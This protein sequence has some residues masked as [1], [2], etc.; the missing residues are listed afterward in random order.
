PHVAVWSL[1]SPFCL[2]LE[3][4]VRAGES[5]AVAASLRSLAPEP[6]PR[7]GGGGGRQAATPAGDGR[8]GGGLQ[9]REHGGGGRGPR[10]LRGQGPGDRFDRHTGR[11]ERLLERRR[12]HQ[13]LNGRTAR[14]I[15][16]ILN[17]PRAR[18]SGRLRFSRPAGFFSSSRPAS[19]GA[20]TASREP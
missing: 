2:A 15:R 14:P 20:T 7:R 4:E 12:R 1:E 6:G 11:P 16:G 19:R 8:A 3:T 17:S 18:G 13:G 5:V 9:G 10:R